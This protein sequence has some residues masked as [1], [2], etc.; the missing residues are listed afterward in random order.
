MGETETPHFYD[1]WISRRVP[2]FQRQLPLSLERL[3]TQTASRQIPGTLLENGTFMNV[4]IPESK[5]V[6]MLGKGGHWKIMK[7]RIKIS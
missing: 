7:I 1:F 5:K 4:K 2:G 3:D 6:D